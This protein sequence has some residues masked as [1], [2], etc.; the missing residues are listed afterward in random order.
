[1]KRKLA[2]AILAGMFAAFSVSGTVLAAE[3]IPTSTINVETPSESVSGEV[4]VEKLSNGA[5]AYVYVPDNELYGVRATA[6]PILVVFGNEAYTSETAK[7]TAEESG[8]AAIADMEQGAVVFVNPIGQEWA[9]EDGTSLEAAKNLFSDSTNNAVHASNFLVN[10]KSEDAAFAGVYQRLYVFAEGAGADFVYSVLSKGVDGS[11]QFFGPATFKPQ[12]AFLM[13]PASTEEIDLTETPEDKEYREIPVVIVNGTDEI[14]AA[15][16]ALNAHAPTVTMESETAEG[17][18]AEVLL[19]AYDDVIEHNIAR[20]QSSVGL[21][22][23]KTTVMYLPG[24]DELGLTEEKKEYTYDDGA[25]LVYYQWTC[26]EEG[27]PLFALFHGSGSC[28]ENIAWTSGLV[29]LAAEKGFNLISF[30]NYS[31]ADLDDDKIM[32][33]ID[34]AIEET[35]SDAG[36][37]YVG[38]FSMGSVKTWALASKY[39]DRIAGALG[40]NGF[41]SGM[42]EEGFAGPVPFFC[43]GGKESYLAGFFEF[44]SADNYTQEAALFKANGVAEDFEFDPEY[45]WGMEPVNIDIEE[46]EEYP[47]LAIE[48]SEFASEDGNIYTMFACASSAGHEPV[49]TAVRAGWNF[50]SIYARDAEGNIVKAE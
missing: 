24:N 27:A 19:K 39:S 18:D 30:E 34:A 4:Y 17:F 47:D 14:I 28:A 7:Q 35:G 29:S 9:E 3:A 50:I 16:T 48:F 8:L 37:L 46:A 45:L 26:G 5:K 12:A 15:Y 10:G 44:P 11:G 25:S 42:A 21:D 2:A 33:A 1:M 31:N 40:M 49:P 23:C 13:N 36:R 41:N 6:A 20:V 32:E 38:G 43:Y 22:Y